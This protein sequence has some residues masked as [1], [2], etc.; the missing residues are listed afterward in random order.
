MDNGLVMVT[1]LTVT[2]L[3]H[4]CKTLNTFERKKKKTKFIN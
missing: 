3:V 2:L 1:M 4:N